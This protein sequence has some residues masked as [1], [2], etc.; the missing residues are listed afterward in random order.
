MIQNDISEY[1]YKLDSNYRAEYEHAKTACVVNNN[2]VSAIIMRM[3]ELLLGKVYGLEY[4]I[5][6]TPYFIDVVM[7]GFNETSLLSFRFLGTDLIRVKGFIIKEAGEF[8]VDLKSVRE[9]DVAAYLADLI[10][11]EYNKWI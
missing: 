11:K 8:A 5:K 10:E 2:T 6:T 1:L 4:S 3:N 7:K 9:S